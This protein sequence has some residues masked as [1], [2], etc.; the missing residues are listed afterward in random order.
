MLNDVAQCCRFALC[1][2]PWLSSDTA[3]GF[4]LHLMSVYMFPKR[5]V[6]PLARIFAHSRVIFL[7]ITIVCAAP[8][9]PPPSPSDINTLGT[10]A[11]V[12]VAILGAVGVAR[13]LGGG[14]TEEGAEEG[15]SGP[16]RAFLRS[17]RVYP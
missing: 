12:G 11:A 17:S 9:S 14:R 2:F 1:P 8:N 5:L 16:Q 15:A 13:V 7:L 6:R 3:V 4:V 10:V